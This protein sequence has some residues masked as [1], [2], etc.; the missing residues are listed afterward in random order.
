MKDPSEQNLILSI[1][2]ACNVLGHHNDRYRDAKF[3]IDQ[4]KGVGMNGLPPIEAES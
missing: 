4:V 3:L 2:K 1:K